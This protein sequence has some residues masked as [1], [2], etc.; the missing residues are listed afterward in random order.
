MS[1]R[2]NK[3]EESD[4]YTQLCNLPPCT[5]EEFAAINREFAEEIRRQG[6][7][8]TVTRN[9][10]TVVLEPVYVGPPRTDLPD[11]ATMNRMIEEEIEEGWLPFWT[12]WTPA[13]RC[14]PYNGKPASPK[15]LIFDGIFVGYIFPNGRVIR[16]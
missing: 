8:K 16:S 4:F 7:P 1:D 6:E 12:H 13:V 11:E 9:G 2:D 5:K 14:K 10:E 3:D 15:P